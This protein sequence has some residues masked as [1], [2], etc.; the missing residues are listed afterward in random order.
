VTKGEGEPTQLCLHA[1]GGMEH[2]GWTQH[3]NLMMVTIL[4]GALSDEASDV[5]R[6]TDCGCP[7]LGSWALFSLQV[8]YGH[9]MSW[10]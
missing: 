10:M 7:I 2:L 1:H 5:Y 9:S 3:L 4:T 8:L 6:V